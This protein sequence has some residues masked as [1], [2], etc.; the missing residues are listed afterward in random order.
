MTRRRRRSGRALA[1]F[2]EVVLDELDACVAGEARARRFKHDRRMIEADAMHLAAVDAQKR[3]QTTV[4]RPEVEHATDASRHV[5]EQDALPF[6]AA[7]ILI[8][9]AQVAQGVLGCRPLVG[10]HAVIIGS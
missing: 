9:S 8:R 5:L 7:W 1:A 3:E 4:A 2:D 10:D 6:G